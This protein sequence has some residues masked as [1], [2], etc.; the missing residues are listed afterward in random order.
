MTKRVWE[1]E[2][3]LQAEG[4]SDRLVTAFCGVS[5]GDLHI[6]IDIV[7]PERPDALQAQFVT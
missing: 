2:V 3:Q 7:F 6:A 4:A 5:C 1:E